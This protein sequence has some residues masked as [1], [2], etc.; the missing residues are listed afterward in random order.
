LARLTAPPNGIVLFAPATGAALAPAAPGVP[1]FLAVGE[2]EMG[3]L[4]TVSERLGALLKDRS[5]S[6]FMM[7]PNSEHLMIVADALEV[8]YEW[9]DQRLA[10]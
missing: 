1:N 8:S 6:K 9:M 5:D 2:Q 7:V 10:D 4:K 3:A